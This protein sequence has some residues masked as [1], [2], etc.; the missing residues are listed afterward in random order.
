[1]RLLEI[2]N[3]CLPTVAG[4][5]AKPENYQWLQFG[6]VQQVSEI[7]LR[8]MAQ[9]DIHCLRVFTADDDETPIGII[10]LGD[11]STVFCSANLW[12]VLG[13]KT[14]A[15]HGY[16]TRAVSVMLDHGFG[17]G[18]ETIHAWAAIENTASIRV[19][20]KNNFQRIGTRR[21]CHHL[22]GRLVD[23]YLF[24]LL[25]EEHARLTATPAACAHPVGDCG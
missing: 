14:Q 11:I 9:R 1:M 2:D 4:W 25:A 20:E 19:L 10:G 16:T 21:R 5:L 17:L 3:S 13:N 18:L 12:Y 23:R 6:G 8:M 22:N 15:G 24:D 7:S